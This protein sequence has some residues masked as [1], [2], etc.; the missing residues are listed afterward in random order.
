M[1]ESVNVTESQDKSLPNVQQTEGLSGQVNSQATTVDNIIGEAV[2]QPTAE[3][4][5]QEELMQILQQTR[6][7]SDTEVPPQEYALEVEGKGIFA[8]RDIH[9]VKA[10]QK[11]GK[12]TAIKVFI[13][14]L[15]CGLI[16]KVKSLL[17]QPRILFF[18]TEQ[19]ATDTKQI[20]LDVARLADIGTDIIDSQLSLHTLRRVDQGQLL[21]LLKKGVETTQPKVVFLDGV[22]EFVASFND[23]TESKQ[24]IKELLKLSE[25]YNCAIVCVLHTNKADED[26][27]MRG[28][29]GTM[30]AQ[31]SSTV[32][33]CKKDAGSKIITVSCSEARHQDMPEWSI[34]Y[35]DEGRIVDADEM[36]RQLLEQ[37]KAEQ[38][39]KRQEA[40]DKEK[41]QKLEQCLRVLRDKGGI[42]PRKQL[43]EILMKV[44]DRQ[45]P[46][47]AS[48]I[49]EWVKGGHVFEADGSIMLSQDMTLSL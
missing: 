11:A 3:E 7:R 10:K 36:R 33:E 29:L 6:I 27:N 25:T 40:I 20:L 15:L 26:H 44:F 35:D 18:D 24:L 42:L 9:A 19:S 28:H 39:Q 30:L 49:S 31:K 37:R 32:L 23:E 2:N 13:A 48:Y 17:K 14:A 47:V 5:E 34:M 41:Q 8:I 12:T 43:T 45:R 16:F 1:S 38:Q 21:P 4:Q 22:V 46:T